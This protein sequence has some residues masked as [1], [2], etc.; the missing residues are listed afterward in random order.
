VRG[1]LWPA[2]CR[3]GAAG[4]SVRVLGEA[5]PSLSAMLTVTS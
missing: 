3:Y 5:I 1:G 4:S 2:D